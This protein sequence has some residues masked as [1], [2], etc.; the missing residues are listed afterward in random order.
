MSKIYV[1]ALNTFREAIRNKILYGVCLFAL[2]LVAVAGFF[3]SVSVNDQSRVVKDF[4]IFSLSLAGVI[5]TILTGVSLLNKEVKQKTIHNI[6]SKPVG[7]SHFLLGK[8]LGLTATVSLLIA[9]MG[10]FFIAVMYF[11]DGQLDL[12]LFQAILF[13]LLEVVVLSAVTIFFSACVVETSLAGIF[14][15]AFYLAGRSL[16]YLYAF[17]EGLFG[18]SKILNFVFEA[19][20]WLLPDLRIYSVGDQIV[21]GI[22][23]TN[24][25]L[26]TALLYT[27]SYAALALLLGTLFF[28]RREL[29]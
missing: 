8:F 3:G 2:V 22:S 15:F 25:Q 7:R 9:L 11:I 20:S 5:S 13:I 16:G 29:V 1:I 24:G 27:I 12:L 18:D 14:T 17:A 6:L 10:F 21:Y 4:G 26:G 23:V 19:I 28:A